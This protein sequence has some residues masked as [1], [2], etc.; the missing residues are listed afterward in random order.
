MTNA[1]EHMGAQTIVLELTS[2]EGSCCCAYP[3]AL[4]R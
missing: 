2:L 4:R 1:V 3:P